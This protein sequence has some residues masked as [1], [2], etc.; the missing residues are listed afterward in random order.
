MKSG[1]MG[2]SN[3]GVSSRVSSPPDTPANL[4]DR[5]L[6]VEFE[7][8]TTDCY[9]SPKAPC[10]QD[11]EKD[12]PVPEHLKPI[13]ADVFL[14]ASP[15]TTT[16]PVPCRLAAAAAQPYDPR[17]PHSPRPSNQ[18]QDITDTD[19]FSSSRRTLCLS[20]PVSL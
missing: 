5:R 9:P 4:S 14:S 18:T 7:E 10:P 3:E 11:M 15:R 8:V 13:C 2:Q 12:W 20:H 19:D 6:P 1:G 17:G 16:A